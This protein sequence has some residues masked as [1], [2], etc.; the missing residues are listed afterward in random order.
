MID[1]TKLYIIEFE[2]KLLKTPSDGAGVF[3]IGINLVTNVF[4]VFAM[5]SRTLMLCQVLLL[6]LLCFFI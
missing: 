6:K 5:L 1:I 4:I 3:A 2:S